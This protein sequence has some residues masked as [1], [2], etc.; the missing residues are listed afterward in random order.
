MITHTRKGSRVYINVNGDWSGDAIISVD[1]FPAVTDLEIPV[2]VMDLL[3]GKIAGHLGHEL[4]P[5]LWC[6]AV[7]IAVE[8]YMGDRARLLLDDL[9]I[10][11]T[12][13]ASTRR[14]G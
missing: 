11:R 13:V 2:P 12:G 10:A 8:A 3:L 5:D 6:E 7:S 9:H 4:T 14:D 1:D